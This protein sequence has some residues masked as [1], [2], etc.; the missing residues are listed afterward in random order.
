MVWGRTFRYVKESVSYSGLLPDVALHI[1]GPSHQERSI[2]LKLTL[3]CK[4]GSN[5]V[6]RETRVLPKRDE[7]ELLDDVRTEKPTKAMPPRRTNQPLFF[8]ES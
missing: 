7:F 6:K 2:H 4:H 3:C 5:V 8:I 1:G